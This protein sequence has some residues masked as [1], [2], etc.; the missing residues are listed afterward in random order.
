MVVLM[1]MLALFLAIAAFLGGS[2]G[3]FHVGSA[4]SAVQD[5]PVKVVDVSAERFAFTPSEIRVPLGTTLQVR[6]QSDDTTHGFRIVGT[7]VSVEIPKRGRGKTTVT[8]TPDKAGRY[9]FECMKV[10]GAGHDFMR[11]T[12]IVTA[13]AATE[14]R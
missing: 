6:L 14:I 8:F 3:D 11:G 12:I 7:D 10:C 1:R 5:R 2:A 9:T 4:R 13:P